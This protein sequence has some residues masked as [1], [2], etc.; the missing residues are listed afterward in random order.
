MRLSRMHVSPECMH[1]ISERTWTHVKIGF[2]VNDIATETAGY[3]TTRMAVAAIN[4]GHEAW[5]MTPGD[6]AYDPDQLDR[7]VVAPDQIRTI[8]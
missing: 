4:R 5:V 7:D 3:S 8:V 2:V 1:F 6:F